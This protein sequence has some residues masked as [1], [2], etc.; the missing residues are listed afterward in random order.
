MSE[1]QDAIKRGDMKKVHHLIKAKATD[2]L[3]AATKALDNGYP[4]TAASYVQTYELKGNTVLDTIDKVSDEHLLEYIGHLYGMYSTDDNVREYL[5]R[6]TVLAR[7][8]L[9]EYRQT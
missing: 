3:V 6:M 1:L 5:S 2:P 9:S 7:E 8:T 4:L